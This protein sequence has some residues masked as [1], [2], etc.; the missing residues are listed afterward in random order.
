MTMITCLCDLTK[1][2][3]KSKPHF[4]SPAPPLAYHKSHL[5]AITNP[6]LIT[7][8]CDSRVVL[9]GCLGHPFFC[10]KS[11]HSVIKTHRPFK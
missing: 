3:G 2:W 11:H 9:R 10:H 4:S 7:R 6:I 5:Y 8:L 1:K